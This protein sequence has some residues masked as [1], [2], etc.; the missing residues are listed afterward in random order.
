MF[1]TTCDFIG[2][3]NFFQTEQMQLTQINA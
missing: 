2:C 3:K 1:A